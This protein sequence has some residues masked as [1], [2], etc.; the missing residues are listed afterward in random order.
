ME[1]LVAAVM[2]VPVIQLALW[3]WHKDLRI[4]FYVLIT[5][6]AIILNFSIV[7]ENVRQ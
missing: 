3:S 2:Q 1:Y 4:F 5:D 6:V 7:F